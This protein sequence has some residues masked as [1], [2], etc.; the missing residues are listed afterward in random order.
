MRLVRSLRLVDEV[1]LSID[2]DL[3]QSLTLRK[4]RETYPAD[5][6]IFANGGDRDP[7]KHALPDN[8]TQSCLECNI[9]TVFG[10]GSHEFEKRDSSSRINLATGHEIS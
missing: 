4:I 8:E 9:K 7:D 3:G 2:K 5:E 1:M 6:L 10:V